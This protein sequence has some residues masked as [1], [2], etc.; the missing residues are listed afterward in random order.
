VP[1]RAQGTDASPLVIEAAASR[2]TA[3]QT[4]RSPRPADWTEFASFVVYFESRLT[5]S[6]AKRRTRIE[7]RT[8]AHHVESGERK[9]WPAIALRDLARWMR[10]FVARSSR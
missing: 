7:Q 8:T 10:A 6:G 9:R 3:R 4:A 1:I 5:P 2:P